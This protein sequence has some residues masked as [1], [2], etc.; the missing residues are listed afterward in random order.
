MTIEILITNQQ[1]LIKINL[2][3]IKRLLRKAL[4]LLV[5]GGLSDKKSILKLLL[6]GKSNIEL[7]VIFINDKTMRKLNLKHRGKNKI[8]DVISFPQITETEYMSVSAEQ[9]PLFLGDIAINLHQAKRQAIQ[10]NSTFYDEVAR[11][12]IHGLLHLTGYD[13]EKNAYQAKKM[14]TLEA[15]LLEMIKT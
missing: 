2:P 11:L 3:R 12:L 5:S 15:K 10:N 1:R 9:I 7:S 13:H 14:A 4:K 8:T 6:F